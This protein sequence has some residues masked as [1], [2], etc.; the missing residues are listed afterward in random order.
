MRSGAG[1][2]A[3]IGLHGGEQG[4]DEGLDRLL[5]REGSGFDRGSVGEPAV[6]EL[7]SDLGLLQFAVPALFEVRPSLLAGGD[8]G[9]AVMREVSGD[10]RDPAMLE[11]A[12][13]AP[14]ERSG[15]ELRREV[16]EGP[17]PGYGTAACI[18]DI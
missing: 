10:R 16:L 2:P 11:A 9:L 17:V 8:R 18:G 6:G 13:E 12:P 5:G 15:G 3:T 1:Q 4:A 7:D 14:G